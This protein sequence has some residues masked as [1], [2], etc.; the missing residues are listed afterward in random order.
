MLL[1]LY[2]AIVFMVLVVLVRGLEQ[3]ARHRKRIDRL[4]N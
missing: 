3:Y 2:F 4:R 1:D